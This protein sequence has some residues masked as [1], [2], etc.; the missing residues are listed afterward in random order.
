MNK[1]DFNLFYMI[2]F[3]IYLKEEWYFSWVNF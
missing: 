1:I 3:H 2:L